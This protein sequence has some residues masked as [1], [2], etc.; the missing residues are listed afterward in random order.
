MTGYMLFYSTCNIGLSLQV[1]ISVNYTPYEG[2][3]LA[4][5][6]SRKLEVFDRKLEGRHFIF[7]FYF[8]MISEIKKR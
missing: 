1:L 7:L 5:Q 6:I 2:F 8:D 3:N 4:N